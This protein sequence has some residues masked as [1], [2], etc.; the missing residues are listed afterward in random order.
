MGQSRW[1]D[2]DKIRRKRTPS[3]PFPRVHCPEECLQAKEVENYQ[4]TSVLM[5]RR[6]KVFFAQLFRQSAQ[7]LRSSQS[8]VMNTV[9]AKQER[10][11]P[12]WQDN[13]TH[14][15]SQQVCWWKNLHLRPMILRKKIYCKSTKNEWKGSHNKIVWLLFCTDTGFLTTVEVGQYFMTKDTE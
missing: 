5:V 13:L 2:D 7:Y 14:C 10:R 4:N 11:D 3:F 12:Y 15:L 1:I 8:C 6:L 9:P